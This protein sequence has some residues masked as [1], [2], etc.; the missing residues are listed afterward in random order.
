[1]QDIR[2]LFLLVINRIIDTTLYATRV[3]IGFI[4]SYIYKHWVASQNKTM[5]CSADCWVVNSWSNDSLV[6]ICLW[7]CTELLQCPTG[8]LKW[9]CQKLS[10]STMSTLDQC[11]F[12][13][14]CHCFC[15]MLW[16]SCWLCVYCTNVKKSGYGEV[17]IMTQLSLGTWG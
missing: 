7:L 12:L 15:L 9:K 3:H 1:M 11:L 8:S 17:Y 6:Y 14:R 10:I 2:D 16:S 5:N 4:D 13:T